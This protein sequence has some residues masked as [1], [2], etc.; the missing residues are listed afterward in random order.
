MNT[1]NFYAG[2]E[3]YAHMMLGCLRGAKGATFRTFAPAAER[4]QLVLDG[5][6]MDMSKCWDGN[7]WELYLP[8]VAS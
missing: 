1:S 5:E 7:F 3:F 2:E 4:V 6:F 8:E